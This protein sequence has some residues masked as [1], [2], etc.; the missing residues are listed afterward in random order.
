MISAYLG[1]SDV[2]GDIVPYFKATC[3][4]PAGPNAG[5]AGVLTELD[6][7]TQAVIKSRNIVEK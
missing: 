2:T 3:Y 6:M 4:G 1:S 5:P 7:G